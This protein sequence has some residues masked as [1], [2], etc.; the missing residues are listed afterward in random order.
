MGSRAGIWDWTGKYQSLVGGLC[1]TWRVRMCFE[2]SIHPQKR[3]NAVYLATRPN[4]ICTYQK[5]NQIENLSLLQIINWQVN[6]QELSLLPPVEILSLLRCRGLDNN[7]PLLF[8][9]L[10]QVSE[11]DLH[12]ALSL[13]Q[14]NIIALIKELNTTSIKKVTIPNTFEQVS[15]LFE[16]CR[17]NVIIEFLW[18]RPSPSIRND[19]ALSQ[20]RSTQQ[21][22]EHKLA[23]SLWFWYNYSN[24]QRSPSLMSAWLVG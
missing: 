2:Q 16:E 22:A 24:L 15:P 21:R 9:S 4:D 6:F 7:I 11:L 8:E 10:N 17:H 5:I 19:T 23:V 13:T 12:D 3:W 20:H 18:V 14:Q 1:R